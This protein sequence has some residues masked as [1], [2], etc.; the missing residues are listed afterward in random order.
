[1]HVDLVI[2]D[3]PRR[4][5]KTATK[6]EPATLPTSLQRQQQTKWSKRT[7]SVQLNHL[8][9]SGGT[10]HIHENVKPVIRIERSTTLRIVRNVHI[11][12]ATEKEP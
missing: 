10:H 8:N 6:Q 9:E 11:I 4:N 7:Q 5:D 3:P 12:V 2:Y 1:M